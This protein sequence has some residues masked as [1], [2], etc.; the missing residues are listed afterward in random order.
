LENFNC[1]INTKEDISNLINKTAFE[2]AVSAKMTVKLV[3]AE[4][5]VV[6]SLWI[7]PNEPVIF[8]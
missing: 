8:T 1:N 5:N 2:L 6:F 3:H 7:K 4:G